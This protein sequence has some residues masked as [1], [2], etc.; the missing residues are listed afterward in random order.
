MVTDHLDVEISPMTSGS[1]SGTNQATSS[2]TLVGT[3]I[4]LRPV[5]SIWS[6]HDVAVVSVWQLDAVVQPLRIAFAWLFKID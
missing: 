2:A 1:A 3:S 5:G 6:P 4:I